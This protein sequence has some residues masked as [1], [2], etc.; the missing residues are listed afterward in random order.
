MKLLAAGLLLALGGC[1]TP[2]NWQRAGL[3]PEILL[4][5]EAEDWGAPLGQASWAER[6]S[7]MGVP[8]D[9]RPIGLRKVRCNG[10]GVFFHCSYTVDYGRNSVVE[11]SHRQRY[12]NVG[13]DENGKWSNDWI[14]LVH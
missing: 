7:G 8:L 4:A 11:G 14:V 1:A 9:A 13:K 2:F 12:V 10:T 6:A 3:T 5:L